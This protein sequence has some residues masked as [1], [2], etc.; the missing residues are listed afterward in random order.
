MTK[1]TDKNITMPESYWR[2]LH[3]LAN[4]NAEGTRGRMLVMLSKLATALP[5]AF[6][7]F[8]PSEK[9]GS[10]PGVDRRS[11][12]EGPGVRVNISLLQ[13]DWAVIQ[14]LANPNTRGYKSTL[15]RHL[16]L[17]AYKNPDRF[18]LYPPSDVAIYREDYTV[19]QEMKVRL[20]KQ[21]R[22]PNW[23]VF[24]QPEDGSGDDTSQE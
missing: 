10:L 21:K 23:G 24:H 18:N 20:A 14:A 12:G 9:K 16:V 11:T 7:I 1:P 8:P 5:E 4:S 13:S 19:S 6:D 3:E 17:T 22:Q 15:L 2:R